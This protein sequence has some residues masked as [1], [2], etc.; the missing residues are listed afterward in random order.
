MTADRIRLLLIEDDEDD[1]LLIRDMLAEMKGMAY[2]LDWVADH[3]AALVAI[4]RQQHDVYLVDYRLGAHTGLD[5]VQA[6]VASDTRAPGILLTG[7]D[8]HGVDVAVMEAGAADYLVKGDMTP[9]LLERAIRYARQ[10]AQ[11]Q[12]TLRQSERRFR[13]LIHHSFDGIV[14]VTSD[15]AIQ[16]AS[17]AMSTILGYAGEELVGSRP[18]ALVHPEDLAGIATAPEALLNRPQ[19]P[20][21]A[22]VRVRHRDGH[23]RWLEVVATNLLDE[24]GV[25]AVILNIRDSTE[26]KQLEERL[27]HQALHDPLTDLPNHGAVV[28]ALNR[29]LAS[30]R[31]YQ[32]P[33]ALLFMDI[34]HFKAINDSYGHQNGDAV[35]QA[36]AAVVHLGLRGTDTLGR[37]GGE[38]F[39]VV[40]PETD[41]AAA[42]LLAERL[43]G[44]V[45]AHRFPSG[46]GR[47]A[48]CS[49]GVAVYPNDGTGRDELISA[50]DRALYAAKRLGRDQ[51]RT[52]NESQA[53]SP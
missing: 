45:A 25:G 26:R 37:W 31:R 33:C 13:T 36:F 47:H 4:G 52:A 19:A 49:I 39:M 16:Y 34:D 42:T 1:Y 38:E 23:Y 11:A 41:L 46:E 50:A 14:L 6:I 18:I 44:A 29:D 24:P 9:A 32:R 43:R 12:I 30:A 3:D 2:T 7:Q 10:H 40:L 22:E 20:V 17:P 35:L 5:L 51:V 48:T 8:D 15:G 21:H 27:V 53:L 28:E